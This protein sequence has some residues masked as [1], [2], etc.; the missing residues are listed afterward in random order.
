MKHLSNYLSKNYLKNYTV[1]EIHPVLTHYD[2]YFSLERNPYIIDNGKLNQFEFVLGITKDTGYEEPDCLIYGLTDFGVIF[3]RKH[4]LERIPDCPV[5]GM[6]S[7][8]YIK[9]YIADKKVI[10]HDCGF[11][12]DECE[13]IGKE[14]IEGI[15]KEN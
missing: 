9:T 4:F 8:K 2:F 5:C 3:H 7:K 11:S 12:N 14:L 15:E 10:Y 6:S 1:K 13:L